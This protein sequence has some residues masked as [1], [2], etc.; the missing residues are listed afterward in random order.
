MEKYVSQASQVSYILHC[1]NVYLQGS[2]YTSG[3]ITIHVHCREKKTNGVL[4]RT[5]VYITYA[6]TYTKASFINA[7][8][9]LFFSIFTQMFNA[10]DQL[11]RM[12]E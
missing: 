3:I 8:K 5:G 9:S 10:L 7:E 4:V 12:R 2:K 6:R 11:F 1:Y